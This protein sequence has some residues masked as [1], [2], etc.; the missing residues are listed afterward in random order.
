MYIEKL[1]RLYATMHAEILQERTAN[2]LEN[3]I[4]ICTYG[5][6][7][8]TDMGE[9]NLLFEIKNLSQGDVY[10]LKET[11]LSMDFTPTEQERVLAG[12]E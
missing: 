3:F 6:T 5:I 10:R 2:K 4:D 1:R 8:A 9:Y 7:G 12:I 11:M